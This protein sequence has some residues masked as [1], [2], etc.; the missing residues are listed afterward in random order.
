MCKMHTTLSSPLFFL[1]CRIP[2]PWELPLRTAYVR[3][4]L[5]TAGA[6]AGQIHPKSLCVARQ[7]TPRRCWR[8]PSARAARRPALTGSEAVLGGA[9]K[10]QHRGCSSRC[11]QIDE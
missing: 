7:Y 9:H 8:H 6:E 11:P 5:G 4:N 2:A 1:G 10:L 3:H